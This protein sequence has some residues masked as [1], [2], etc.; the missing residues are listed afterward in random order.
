[1]RNP[2]SGDVPHRSRRI[3]NHPMAASARTRFRGSTKTVITT[4]QPRRM[5]NS[6][7]SIISKGSWRAAVAF[8]AWEQ[9]TRAT[10]SPGAHQPPTTATWR[11][12]IGR[13]V[14]RI[15]RFLRTRDLQ[16]SRDRRSPRTKFMIAIRRSRLKVS[17][18]LRRCHLTA[19]RLAQM[20]KR[21]LC[22]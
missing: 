17:I 8:T 3:T 15:K 11:G 16:Y 13:D 10:A 7:A 22:R 2:K 14:E 5:L 6:P 19:S 21:L 9:T 1:M 12:N 20:A 4:N 18:G